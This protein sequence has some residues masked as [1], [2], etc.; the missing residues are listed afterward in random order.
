MDT[1]AG[2]GTGSGTGRRGTRFTLLKQIFIKKNFVIKKGSA[3]SYSK[4][5]ARFLQKKK[6]DPRKKGN[7]IFEPPSHLA[8]ILLY[9]IKNAFLFA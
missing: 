1:S 8:I 4:Y 7:I 3:S 2:C 9:T 6:F 5:S